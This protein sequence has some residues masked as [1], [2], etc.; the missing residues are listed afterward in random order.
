MKAL[1][2]LPVLTLLLGLAA[3][4]TPT[5]AGRAALSRG[6]YDEAARHFEEALAAEP[7]RVGAL[8]GLG[9]ARYKLDALDDARRAFDA[10]LVQ[11]PDLPPAHL[12]LALIALR[13]SDDAAAETHL[14]SYL[15]LGP[16]ARLAAQLDR[17]RRALSGPLT[18]EMRAYM[19]AALEDGYQ[20]AGEVAVA[21]QAARD[22]DLFWFSH[23]RI[24]IF[25]THCRC[26]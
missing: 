10:A 4:A 8:V 5:L 23:E 7:G 12:Y 21:L 2:R 17:T 6:S 3:C 14:T 19:A 15:A 13:Q 20:W 22:A 11:V 9:V 18:P 26:R 24:Y 25:P 16:P 1:A